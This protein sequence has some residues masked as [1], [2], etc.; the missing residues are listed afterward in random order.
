MKGWMLYMV[1]FHLPTTKQFKWGGESTEDYLHSG[2]PVEAS[3]KEMC[4]KVEDMILQDRCIKISVTAHEVGISAG[5]VSSIIH[6]VLMILKVSSWWVPWKLTAEQEACRQQF[7]EE[8]LDMFR[9]NPENFFTRII[10]RVH[11]YDPETKQGSMKWKH[12][13]YPTPKKF[14]VQQSTGKI[15]ATVFLWFRRCSAF[16]IHVTQNN[17]YWRHLCFHNGGFMREY[18]TNAMKSC[19]LVSCCFL[20]MHP[21]TS[22]AHHRLL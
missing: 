11:N 17:H 4:Q 3:S 14:R 8:N 13:E 22:H 9:A 18:Q 1:K 7:S 6:S 16:G 15:K 5:T 20:T 19:R 12:K 10:T 21:H 2:R